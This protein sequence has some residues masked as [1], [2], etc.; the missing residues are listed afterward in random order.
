MPHVELVGWGLKVLGRADVASSSE[1]ATFGTPGWEA[2][3]VPPKLSSR[4]YPPTSA[5]S[6]AI[7]TLVY[8]TFCAPVNA[9]L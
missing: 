8:C 5:K 2:S 4:E 1:L 6:W 3:T 7:A 9:S